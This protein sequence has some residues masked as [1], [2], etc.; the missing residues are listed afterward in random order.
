MVGIDGL[1]AGA[2]VREVNVQQRDKGPVIYAV[3]KADGRTEL[4]PESVGAAIEA[5]N[6]KQ[7]TIK[8][9]TVTMTDADQQYLTKLGGGT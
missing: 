1:M 8:R 6:A 5:Y 7:D 3:Y 4:D 2:L 9:R